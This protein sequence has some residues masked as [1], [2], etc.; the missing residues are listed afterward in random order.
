MAPFIHAQ[1]SCV[2]DRNNQT[3]SQCS[4]A[5]SGEN[6]RCSSSV[7]G[8]HKCTNATKCAPARRSEATGPQIS[9]TASYGGGRV[10]T[11][12]AGERQSELEEE[13]RQYENAA[14]VSFYST[15][16]RVSASPVPGDG[17]PISLLRF[18]GRWAV[19]GL[20]EILLNRVVQRNVVEGIFRGW[21]V[22]DLR[23]DDVPTLLAPASTPFPR[24]FLQRPQIS[25][26][27]QHRQRLH[28]YFS[29]VFLPSSAKHFIE[30]MQYA[31]IP[32]ERTA[33][34]R[35]TGLCMVKC[36]RTRDHHT[37]LFS[38]VLDEAVWADC[39]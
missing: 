10:G 1:D 19:H 11:L 5:L 21:N 27:L 14:S 18:D 16:A 3:S 39:G 8:V 2:K 20:S 34:K 15:Q 29:G 12:S 23:V 30:S 37:N 32:C 33:R 9:R 35:R 7:K 38:S 6:S 26:H 25:H 22:G 24:A 36:H 28:V 4:S 13:L 17:G 31:L